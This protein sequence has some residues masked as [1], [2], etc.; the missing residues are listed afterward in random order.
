MQLNQLLLSICYVEATVKE[1]TG[2]SSQENAQLFPPG[3]GAGT[4]A[5]AAREARG[6]G[7]SRRE[8]R[9]GLH[10]GLPPGSP[11]LLSG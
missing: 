10:P 11:P 9:I 4:V 6:T 8:M 3:R 1:K 2:K 5:C 7:G